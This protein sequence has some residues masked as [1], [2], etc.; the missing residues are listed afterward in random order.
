MRI[1]ARKSGLITQGIVISDISAPAMERV[2]AGGK[3]RTPKVQCI[4]WERR[5]SDEFAA[6]PIWTLYASSNGNGPIE[7]F[8]FEPSLSE[9]RLKHQ[10][11]YWKRVAKAIDQLPA[12]IVAVRSSRNG[13]SW[14]GREQLDSTP[15][16][17]VEQMLTGL[18]ELMEANIE[19]EKEMLDR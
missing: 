4:A 18:Q 6:M 10:E 11:E 15:D 12:D 14:I 19:I 13:A 7:G 9:T 8:I 17:F 5:Y 16:A 3:I 2:T 1:D